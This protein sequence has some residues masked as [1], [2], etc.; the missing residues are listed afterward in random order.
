MTRLKDVMNV[1]MTNVIERPPNWKAIIEVFPLVEYRR[2]VMFCYG[3]KIYNPDGIH[4]PP[5]LLA[6]EATHSLQQ[7]GCPESWWRDYLAERKFRLAMETEAHVVE[8]E[9]FNEHHNR[10]M[11]RGYLRDCADRLS[12]SLYGN[13]IKPREARQIIKERI[14]EP[15]D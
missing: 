7:C 5:W 10:G 1:E 13:L 15:A 9:A 3:N 12:G 8:V 14:N 2:G 6:H 4:I 11:R